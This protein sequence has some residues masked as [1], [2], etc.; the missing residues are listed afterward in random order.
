MTY[1]HKAKDKRDNLGL[2]VVYEIESG[3]VVKRTKSI[4]AAAKWIYNNNN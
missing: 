4:S 3:V 2:V 1:K